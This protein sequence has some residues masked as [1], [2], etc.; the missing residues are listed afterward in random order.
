MNKNNYA[1]HYRNLQQCLELGMKLKKIHRILKFKQ[2]DWMRP[3][4][5]F[6]IDKTK[7]STNEFFF[8]LMNNLVYSKTIENLRK[9]I[10][11][12]V[13]KN[14]PEFIKYTSRPTCVNWKVFEKNLAAIHE[15]KISLTLNKLIYVGTR[16]W[17]Y[18]MG[19]FGSIYSIRNK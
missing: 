15:K 16:K 5:D 11:I 4:I 2:S 14:S 1:I 17:E 19:V 8:K 9:R 10:K 12:R 18:Q 13:V 7:E 3:Y 6:D